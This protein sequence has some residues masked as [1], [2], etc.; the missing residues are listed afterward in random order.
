MIEKILNLIPEKEIINFLKEK[1]YIVKE[2]KKQIEHA[3]KAR[4]ERSKKIKEKIENFLKENPNISVNK[5]AKELGINWRTVKK[6]KEE[7]QK[8]VNA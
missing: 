2:K 8:K 4:E 5:I 3:Q 6:Y 7:L 1:G